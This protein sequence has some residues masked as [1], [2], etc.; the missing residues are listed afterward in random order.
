MKFTCNVCGLPD[1][2]LLPAHHEDPELPSCTSCG[3]NVRFRWLVDRLGRELL[4]RRT[5]LPYFPVDGAIRGLG[6]TDPFCI[7]RPLAD[8]FTYLNT[9]FDTEPRFDIRSG[10]SP[11][12]ELDFLI[13][14]EVFEHIEPPVSVAFHNAARLLKPG[15]IFLLTTPWIWD[16]SERDVLPELYDWRLDYAGGSCSIM[17]RT[18]D[19]EV[20]WH[21]DLRADGGPGSSFGTTREHFPNLYNW[22]LIEENGEW[23]LENRRRD[24][25]L[26]VFHNLCFHGGRGLALEMRIFAK[27]SLE[28]E[29]REAGFS[30]IEFDNQENADCGIIFP[31]PWNYPI[32][33]R[34]APDSHR[35]V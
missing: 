3:S 12:G 17:N 35:I 2:E 6:L 31:Y 8:R 34:K 5:L 10:D 7:A 18:R 21:R 23:R 14:S 30:S 13:A 29:L 19:G 26:E 28:K 11:L 25:G 16:G 27:R 4:G 20:E 15:G 33:A 24:G 9:F 22:R 32:V 1:N